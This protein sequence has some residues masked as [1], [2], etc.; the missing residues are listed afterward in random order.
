YRAHCRKRGRHG[1]QRK[2]GKR[3]FQLLEPRHGENVFF[4]P[5]RLRAERRKFIRKQSVQFFGR[6]D[7]D[8]IRSRGILFR[9]ESVTEIRIKRFR[10]GRKQHAAERSL[11]LRKVSSVRAAEHYDG[12]CLFK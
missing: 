9:N 12:I 1:S 7:D 10:I 5:Y 6:S 3:F 8:L 11:R 2:S 4:V